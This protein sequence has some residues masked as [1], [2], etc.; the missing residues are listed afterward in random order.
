VTETR[1][2]A[3]I[4]TAL[5]LEYE[6]VRRQLADVRT[7]HHE[8]GTIY[9]LGTLVGATYPR[10][11][12]L[13]MGGMGNVASG[14][15][16]ERAIATF[17][18]Q[19]VVFVGVAGGLKDV[20]LGDVVV[21]TK[22]YG[23]EGGKAETEFL[24]RPSVGEAS[25]RLR[26]LAEAVQREGNW[27]RRID[28]GVPSHEAVRVV[29]GPIVAGEKVVAATTSDV[30][31]ILRKHYSDAVAVEMESAGFVHALS[32]NQPRESLIVRGISDLID[33]K[34]HADA[35]GW[36]DRAV[37]HAAAFA[38]AVLAAFDPGVGAKQRPTP[39]RRVS[40]TPSSDV[41][42]SPATQELTDERWTRLQR[43]ME[44]L[45]PSGPRHEEI[46]RRAGG[47]LA[48]LGPATSGRAWWFDTLT[49]LRNGGGGTAIT[50]RSLLDTV[51]GDY[52]KDVEAGKMSA[53]LE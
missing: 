50:A 29:L 33:G 6:S 2:R 13:V 9:E 14:I 17:D 7:V 32:R 5:R 4:V 16:T 10:E 8:Q 42:E 34:G 47:D 26:Q 21:G 49:R 38:T 15:E 18:P 25:Y 48:S 30:Y 36:Q 40:A 45:Y 20:Q 1:T 35:A 19:I 37:A 43:L 52:P 28:E 11:V 23:Y 51:R 3:V 44:R 22:V 31:G 41:S 46:W 24:P 53:F 12:A 27:R 39:R